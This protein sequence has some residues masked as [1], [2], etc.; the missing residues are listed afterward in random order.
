M[1]DNYKWDNYES[2]VDPCKTCKHHHPNKSSDGGSGASVWGMLFIV[3]CVACFGLY[4]FWQA[5]EAKLKNCIYLDEK[6]G[7]HSVK[8]GQ[9]WN[10]LDADYLKSLLENPYGDG[11]EIRD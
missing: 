3:A 1:E 5:D 9:D 11:F 6:G 4:T 2:N 8:D 7:V 10:M